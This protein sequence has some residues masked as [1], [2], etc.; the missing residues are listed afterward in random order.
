MTISIRDVHKRDKGIWL[1]LWE[2][3][4]IFYKASLSQEQTELT[5]SRL[6]DPEFNMHGLV[7]ESNGEVVGFTH[8]LF[9]PSTWAVNDY[10]YLED[11][12]VDPAIRGKGAGRALISAVVERA[13]DAKSN[14]VYWT[15]QNTNAQARILYD[16]FGFPSEFVQYR[17]PLQ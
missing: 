1:K 3:Y 11:L 8:Y 16:S 13:K 5:W 4:L 2:G 9:R 15:T 10:C 7:A 14:R 6:H 17:I 12:Y